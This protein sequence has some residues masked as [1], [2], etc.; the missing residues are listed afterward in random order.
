MLDEVIVESGDVNIID[1]VMKCLWYIEIIGEEI[2]YLLYFE[3]RL[4]R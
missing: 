4:D 1:I 3:Y 2:V